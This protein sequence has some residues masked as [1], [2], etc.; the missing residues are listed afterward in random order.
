MKKSLAKYAPLVFWVLLPIIISAC[1]NVTRHTPQTLEEQRK[2]E[3]GKFFGE[4]GLSFNFGGDDDDK[5]A[6]SGLA[7][8]A[9][10]WRAALDTV[11]FMPISQADPFGGV[12][13]T[14]WYADSTD[15]TQR[16]KLNI[17]ILGQQLEAN[18]LRVSVFK[19]TRDASGTWVEQDVAED[20]AMKVEDSILTRARQLRIAS[21]NKIED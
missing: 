19:Q 13:I 8:N 1:G 12:I 4:D 21:L 14:D 3:Q 17:F 5:N 11:S 10:L 9:F 20:T 7:V 18:G 6:T 15:S 16:Y 2:S